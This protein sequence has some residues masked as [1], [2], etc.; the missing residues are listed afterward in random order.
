MSSIFSL[1]IGGNSYAQTIRYVKEGGTGDG[2]SWAN[3]SGD[4]QAMINASADGEQVWVAAGTYKP[5]T[6]TANV[7]IT[8][9]LKNG[10]KLLGGFP[11][12]N[13]PTLADRNWVLNPTILSGNIGNVNDEKDNAFHV[14]SILDIGGSSPN[15]TTLDGFIISDGYADDRNDVNNSYNSG[16]GIYIYGNSPVIQNCILKNNFGRLVGG[17]GV[18]FSNPTI[19]NCQFYN[20]R[21]ATSAIKFENSSPNLK[22]ST[23]HSA[24][25]RLI[26]SATG[27]SVTIANCI[28]W[29]NDAPV[30]NTGGGTGISYS[31][32]Q[33]GYAGTGNRST[34]PDFLDAANGNFNVS[35][36]SCAIDGGTNSAVVSG[37]T[38]F[39]KN[40]RIYNNGTVDMGAY[41]YQGARQIVSPIITTN[42]ALHFDGTNDYVSLAPVS[43]VNCTSATL[44]LSD[45]LTIEYWFKGTNI[46][47]AVRFQSGANYISSGWGTAGNFKHILSNSGGTDGVAVGSAATDGNW[48]HVAVTWQKGA[49]NGFKSYLDG[50]LVEQKNATNTD[51]PS[52][53]AGLSLG[54]LN[55][56]GEFMNGS[57]DE[58]KVWNVVRTQAEIQA[59]QCGNLSLPQT[60]LLMYYQFN[61][62]AVN[63]TNANVKKLTNLADPNNTYIGTLNGFA[64]DGSTS[65]W[66]AAPTGP[67]IRY[68]KPGGTGDG[69][70]WANASGNL[71]AMIGASCVQQVWVAA[72]TYKPSSSPG[73]TNCD[74]NRDYYFLLKNGVKLYGGFA[75]NETSVNDR[76]IVANPTILSGDLLGNDGANFANADDNTYHVVVA[77]FSNTTPTIE[78]DGFTIAGGNATGSFSVTINGQSVSRSE[79]G[80]MYI[81]GGTTTLKNNTITKNQSSN[82]GGIY[83]KDSNITLESNTISENQSSNN[84]GGGY[85]YNGTNTLVN[86]L[87]VGNSSRDGGGLHTFFGGGV[88]LVNNTFTGNSANSGGALR[89]F[90]TNMTLTNNI[91]WG[92]SN[93]TNEIVQIGGTVSVA[94]SIVQGGYV[95]N[96]NLNI[97][98][99]FVAPSDGNFRLQAQ[100]CAINTGDNGSVLSGMTTDR[101]GAT[102][103]FNGGTVDLGAFEFQG[104]KQSST[105]NLPAVTT[106]NALNFDG[107]NDF[108]SISTTNAANC[109]PVPL[110]LGDNFTIEYWFKGSDIRSAV[111]LKAGNQF[112]SSGYGSAGSYTHT[113]GFGGSSVGVSVGQAATD[114]NWHHIAM[115][116]Q[117]FDQNGFK[118][119]LDGELVEQKFGMAY[120]LTAFDTG[121]TLGN[122]NGSSSTPE[123]TNGSIDELRIWNVART[124]VEI[125][126]GLCGSLSLP[127]TGL[128]MYYQFDHGG[129]NGNNTNISKLANAA[130]PNVYAGTLNGFALN[131][132]TSNW[133]AAKPTSAIRY[134][135]AGASG[136]GSSWADASGNLQAMI[137]ANCVEQVW[138]AAGTYKPGTSRSESFVMKA[139]VK[140]YGGFPAIGTPT[141]A[142]RNWKTNV[143]VLSGDLNG[144]DV[145]TGSGSSLNI[146]NTAENSFYVVKND[147]NGLTSTA[148]L[149]GF[150]ITGGNANAS[151]TDAGGGLFI[152]L[153]SPTLENLLITANSASN[154]AGAFIANSSS[155]LTN[156]SFVKNKAELDGGG[157]YLL[158]ATPTFI[159]ALF[160]GNSAVQGGGGLVRFSNANFNHVT[161]AGNA[162]TDGGGEM[163]TISSA[164]TIKNSIIW[165]QNTGISIG[166]GLPVV[167]YSIIKGGFSGTGN[168]GADPLFVNVP[169]GDLGLQACSPAINAGDNA[170]AAVTDMAG[171]PRIVGGKV[172]MGAYE[173]QL[174][175]PAAITPSVSVT[176][177]TTCGG[178]NGSIVLGGFLNATTYSVTYKKN[179]V[180]VAAANFTSNGSGVITLTGLGA[181][182]YTE[183]VATYGACVTN[184]VSTTL[185]DPSKPIALITGTA[186]VCLNGPSPSI[187]FTGQNGITPYTFTYKVNEGAPQ[188]VQTS[189]SNNSVVVPVPTNVSGV[190]SFTLESVS[191]PTNCSQAQTGS[192]TVTVQGKPTI[193]LTTLQQ[194]LNE[195][196]A[197]T[198]CDTDANPVNGLQFNVTGLCMVGNPVWRVQVGTGAW[199]NWSA[200]APVSQSSNN[201]PHR[202]QAACDANCSVTYT[203]PIELTINNRASIPQNVSLLV[204]GVTVAVG[205]TKEVCSLVTTSLTFNANCATG[206]V[207]LYSVDGGEYSAGVPVGLV[208]NQFHNYRV[209]CRKSDGTPSCVES[210]SGVMRLKLVVIPAAPTVSLSSTSSCNPSASFSGQST[211]GSLRTVW[212]NATTNVALPS[213][214]STV[215][216][217]TTSYY[218]RCQTENGCVSEKSNVVTFT[219]TPTQVAPVI[220]ISQEI[221]CT[222]T[223]VRVSANCPAG[224]QTFWNT[225]V[226]APS[227]EVAFNNVTKQ[228]YWAKCLFDGGCQSAESVRKDIY[229]NAFVV[230]LIN[231]GES[232]SAIKTNDRAAWR[233]QFITRD[234]GPELEQST[235]VNPTLYYVENANKTA[236]R[237]WTINVEACGLSA[238]GSLTFDMLVTP[239][240]GVIRSFNTHENNTPYFMYANR[241]GW[242]ELYA[243]NHPA[244]G[245]YQDN[246]A[247]GNVYD[248]GL[249]KGLYKLGI[250][251]WDQKGWGSIYPST[252]KPQGNVLTYQEYWFRIQSKDGVGVGAARSAVSEEANGKGQGARGE[253]QEANGKWQGSDNGQPITDNGAFATVLPN[254]V[255]NILR[256][257]VQDSKGQ[258][259]QAALT[260]AS[261]REVL[262]RQFVPETNT[263]QE[264]FGVR[265]LPMGIYFLKVSTEMQQATLKVVKVE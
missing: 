49:V 154:G 134:V 77:T 177:P 150:T 143:T 22:N 110:N 109:T 40:P 259:V 51:L 239:E 74:T 192:A 111:F 33:G 45:A 152:G 194:T 245:F 136:S 213:L 172:D 28:I 67:P 208:D 34:D 93:G 216:S 169:N 50:Q 94:N 251:Y 65:N 128:L 159:N 58:V 160:W 15:P 196:N 61:H 6:A 210:E 68:V 41:E 83:T 122:N 106:N 156:V 151:S 129:A 190:V 170:G 120:P 97:D 62:G 244:Y 235:Q 153:S 4:L 191:N 168:K 187:T 73:C 56:A 57:L 184:A 35:P 27:G 139:G 85:I 116:W 75:G 112:I 117:R 14:V 103:I 229:W 44:T 24:T 55:G 131:G 214:P 260:D 247:G 25:T 230:T 29:G 155:S 142:D 232:K 10:V 225:G 173:Y 95:G 31:I 141:F 60:G 188:T 137:N 189:G 234:G 242:T 246:G 158:G 183:I 63:G 78:L 180:E 21:G 193:T 200:T 182:N 42:N 224:S 8:F 23:L 59:G 204:D 11:A 161:M 165:G 144:D 164:P 218:A 254:P 104:N 265:E 48:H 53:S 261:G 76:N 72:G 119:Y 202:Y 197:Q 236:P 89:T 148:V 199:S 47:S 37:E 86:N 198:F 79:G 102:R 162:T 186:L 179:N 262:R 228:T 5:T 220:T 114:G 257:K 18:A 243:Q 80:G 71:Q 201:Q 9:A 118:S 66:V 64:L 20:N 43:P 108:V 19:S 241:D 16:G 70:D 178:G 233:S 133:V 91:L 7:G 3:A 69:S 126:A 203:S 123:Y 46:Q 98:P 248:A 256:L 215:P 96:G 211:C 176:H 1:L 258:T 87:V 238:D 217:Q 226:T 237:Y 105:F 121:L 223:T 12:T 163:M 130:D 207:I 101:A 255:T 113:I 138:V 263:H 147:N 38:D 88:L 231:I 30:A 125:Q 146:S 181:G 124:Q 175:L 240:T 195:G 222:G 100:S 166:S 115:T 145:I 212:Y 221:V 84:G 54:S 107:S 227:F 249:P 26:E 132:S 171:N 149:D 209:R 157:V 205:E 82:G 90:S 32:V 135:K 206:E 13:N 185:N 2:S 167:T 140:I 52:F 81:F 219:L 99:L 39:D 36:F 92:N 253:G 127:Q 174:A 250:R 264:E 252:R 17:M